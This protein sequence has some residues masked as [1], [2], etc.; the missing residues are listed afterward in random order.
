MIE[1]NNTLANTNSVPPRDFFFPLSL[2]AS[3]SPC[4]VFFFFLSLRASVS[5]CEV[6]FLLFP[7]FLR[8]SAPLREIMENMCRTPPSLKE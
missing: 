6:F 1:E 4:E 5:L 8:A 7:F 2:R 3:V